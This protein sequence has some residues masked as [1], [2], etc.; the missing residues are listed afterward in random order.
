MTMKEQSN[1]P[2]VVEAFLNGMNN[3]SNSDMIR[4]NY[5]NTLDRI[6]TVIASE[7]AQYD[8]KVWKK[9]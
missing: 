7:V 6:A 8:Q 5:R 2:P 4:D 3:P 9:K 1:L